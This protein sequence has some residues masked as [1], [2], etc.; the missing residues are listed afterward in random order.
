MDHFQNGFSGKILD[1]RLLVC[2]KLSYFYDDPMGSSKLYLTIRTMQC[3]QESLMHREIKV[4]NLIHSNSAIGMIVDLPVLEQPNQLSV[5]HFFH[6]FSD[7][8]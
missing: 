2:C 8:D 6:A 5:S 1:G 4:D 7:K 3:M